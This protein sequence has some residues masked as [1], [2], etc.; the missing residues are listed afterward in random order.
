MVETFLEIARPVQTPPQS[1]PVEL[2]KHINR[3]TAATAIEDAIRKAIEQ[4]YA[5]AQAQLNRAIETIQASIS[6][7]DRSTANYCEDLI[8]DLKEC[9][10]GMENPH[11]F[12][13]AGIHYAHSYSTMYFLERSTGAWNLRGLK[14]I[15]NDQLLQQQQQLL[16]EQKKRHAGYGYVTEKQEQLAKKAVNEVTHY[17]QGYLEE[18]VK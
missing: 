15:L 16:S 18:E 1:I 17:V 5:T 7:K 12:S 10:E 11:I 8:S 3:F 2:D 9:A 14:V 4:Q 13:T 6:A